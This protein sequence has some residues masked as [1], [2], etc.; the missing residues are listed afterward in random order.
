MLFTR[1]LI[2]VNSK[3]NMIFEIKVMLVFLIQD[4]RN[5]ENC[6]KYLAKLLHPKGVHWLC[7]EFISGT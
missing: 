1:P 7:G 4:F 2:R 5:H 3:E 6:Y